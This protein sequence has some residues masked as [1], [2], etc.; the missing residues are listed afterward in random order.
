[1][2][3]SPAGFGVVGKAWLPRRKFAGTMDAAFVESKKPLPDDFDFSYW[4][5]AP[6]DMQL[7][8]LLGGE[9]IELTGFSIQR[10]ELPKRNILAHVVYAS[11]KMALMDFNL[12]TL[13]L[14]LDNSTVAAVYRLKLPADPLLESISTHFLTDQGRADLEQFCVETGGAIH[15]E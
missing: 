11:E 3:Y 8:W 12:D 1:M 4:N 9:V 14:D 6:A 2:T 7:P 13:F 5:G 15:G 10:I